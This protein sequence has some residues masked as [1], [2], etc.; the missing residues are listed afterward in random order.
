MIFSK[1][2]NVFGVGLIGVGLWMSMAH[3]VF[4]HVSS[5]M[6]AHQVVGIGLMIAGFVV[7]VLKN[8]SK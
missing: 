1:V 2:V 8:H 6:S 7:L 5:G 3:H 4:G